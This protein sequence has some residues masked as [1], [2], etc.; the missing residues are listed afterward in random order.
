M[1]PPPLLLEEHARSK[2]TGRKTNES[3]LKS[4]DNAVAVLAGADAAVGAFGGYG[5][6]A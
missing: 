4:C 5:V 1:L 2:T 6:V 3:H